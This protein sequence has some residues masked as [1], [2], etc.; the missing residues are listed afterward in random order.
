MDE[1]TEKKQDKL[2]RRK[3][4]ERKAN[5]DQMTAAMLSTRQ[6]RDW[7]AWLLT[8]APTRRCSFTNNALSTAFNAG[9]TNVGLQIEAH[10]IEIAPKGYVLMLEELQQDANDGR[11]TDD[12]DTEPDAGDTSSAG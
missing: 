3:A 5:V 4:A 8:L 2:R 10:L 9:E 7:F 1:A 6:G 11:S 12:S